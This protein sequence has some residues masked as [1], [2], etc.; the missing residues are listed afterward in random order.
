[1]AH[2]SSPKLYRFCYQLSW[3]TIALLFLITYQNVKNVVAYYGVFFNLVKCS[4][5]LI[6]WFMEH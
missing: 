3:V 4:F 1:M 6:H 2:L 5:L